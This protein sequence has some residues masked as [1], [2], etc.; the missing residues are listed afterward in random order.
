MENIFFE[1]HAGLPREAPGDDAATLQAFRL[2]KNLPAVPTILDIGC[3]PG[4]QTIA[5][6]RHSAAQITALDLHQP[7]LDDLT[8]RSAAAGLKDR[9]KTINASMFELSFD[10]PFDVIWSEGAIYIIGF[11]E[12]LRA[13]HPL[14]KPGGC[15]AVTEL[16]WIKPDPPDE[17]LK[18]WQADYPGMVSV[19]QNLARLRAADYREIGYFILPESAWWDPYYRPMTAKIA[20][21]RG[22]YH[23]DPE[24]QRLLDIQSL[25]IEMYRKYSNWYG[26]VFYVMQA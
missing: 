13:W 19:D 11:S 1:I 18:Y 10:E 26:Y 24:A 15:V 25:E 8:R 2:I 3:G 20:Q 17:V 16:S 12:G 7:F 22:K 9:I 5:L 14:L 23:A 6:A 4:A 21:L